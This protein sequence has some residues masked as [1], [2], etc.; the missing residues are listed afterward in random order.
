[1][2]EGREKVVNLIRNSENSVAC[3][4]EEERQEKWKREKEE[5]RTDRC[6]ENRFIK[7]NKYIF[8]SFKSFVLS[9]TYIT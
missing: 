8:F 2:E 5:R 6:M 4:L 7:I 1:M 9:H 3:R